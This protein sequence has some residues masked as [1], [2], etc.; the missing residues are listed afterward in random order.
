[1]TNSE[2]ILP[3][4]GS[5]IPA[6]LATQVTTQK[7]TGSKEA[8]SESQTRF[9]RVRKRLEEQERSLQDN[10]LITEKLNE[11]IVRLR[12]D[13]DEQLQKSSI[14][15]AHEQVDAKQVRKKHYEQEIKR[16]H[17]ALHDF[18][19]EHLAA[20]IAA[21]ELGGPTVGDMLDVNEE[22]LGNG[23]SAQGKPKTASSASK[24]KKNQMR[25]DRH[26][27]LV[28][29]SEEDETTSKD[30]AAACTKQ[31]L[32]ELLDALLGQDASGGYV[33]LQRD[34]AA[35]RFFVRAK[36]AQFHPKDARRLRLIDFARTLDD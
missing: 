15:I 20:M 12:Q 10:N 17:Q 7:I 30:E 33:T 14:D 13:K 3:S 4:I 32:E 5:P 19:D 24:T 31:L 6:L 11:R 35:A 8:I 2:P 1:M 21:E 27:N 22:M 9:L 25:L 34:S 26:G 36:V 18:I 29:R 16:Y 23:F 28:R